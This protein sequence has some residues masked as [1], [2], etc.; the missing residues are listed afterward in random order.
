MTTVG[1]AAVDGIPGAFWPPDWQVFRSLL[2]ATAAAGPGDLA[3][4]GVLYGRSAV[5]I[6]GSLR[7]GETFT[8][9]D[10]FEAEPDDAANA[11]ENAQSYPGLSRAAFEDNYRRV[12][13]RLP[14]VVVGPSESVVDHVPAASHRFVHV[15]ASHLHEHVVKD[16][17]ASRRIL[18]ADGVLALDDIR[19]PHTPGVAAAAWQAVLTSGLRPIAVSTYKLYATFG[20]P[21]PF[22]RA[23]L[24]LAATGAVEHEVQVVNGEPLVRVWQPR[25]APVLPWRRWVPEVAWPA[26][27]WTGGRALRASRRVRGRRVP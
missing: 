12:H 11:V 9:V 25:R 22:R 10:L 1:D 21:E 13:G 18:R 5:L 2:D 17:D 14:A 26:V 8:V 16:I 27:S 23:L 6:G 3:E 15:D 24:D 20:D 7:D 4:L 19:S